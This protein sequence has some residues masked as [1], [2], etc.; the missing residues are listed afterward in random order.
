[1]KYKI[2][3][4]SVTLMLPFSSYSKI[5]RDPLSSF[6]PLSGLLVLYCT[7][8]LNLLLK[9]LLYVMPVLVHIRFICVG[10]DISIHV[11]LTGGRI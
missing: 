9:S 11:L 3:L 5:R 2:Q 4:L 8:V 6:S 10:V 1:M 7:I